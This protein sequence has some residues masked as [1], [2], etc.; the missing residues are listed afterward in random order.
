MFTYCPHC[1]STKI[2]YTQQRFSCNNCGFTFYQNVAAATACIISTK[3]GILFEVRGKEP[4]KDKL[5]F[6]GG[7]IN[8]GDGAVEGVRRECIEEIGWDPGENL[9]FMASFPNIYPYKGIVYHSCDLYFTVSAPELTLSDLTLDMK[10]T[11]DIRFISPD[12]INIDDIAFD[13][14]K[15]ALH[16]FIMNSTGEDSK[17]H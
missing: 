4:G 12:E 9:R 7:F 5:G 1:A 15:K 14:G 3:K 2:L 6:P 17:S 16:Y 10:E 13:A 11:R 8:P